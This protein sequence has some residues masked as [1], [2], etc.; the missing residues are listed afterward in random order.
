[1]D[2]GAERVCL[3]VGVVHPGAE[4]DLVQANLRDPSPRRRANALEILDNVL[5]K[6]VKRRLVPLLDDRPR[7]ARLRE[8]VGLYPL[9]R[10]DAAGWLAHL[11]GDDSP[12]MA[13]AA[14]WHCGE[15]GTAPLEP[16]LVEL[17]EHRVPFVREA[18]FIALERLPAG[19][20]LAAAAQRA[21]ADPFE[22][23]R[24]RAQALVEAQAAP[25]TASA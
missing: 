21:A 15:S 1:V 18:A 6:A 4:L 2:R 17:L 16:R 23:L 8:G 9:P 19:P 22:P 5:D 24:A 7:E 20:G 13:A 11:L 25:R 10:L 12:W 14:A 3:L